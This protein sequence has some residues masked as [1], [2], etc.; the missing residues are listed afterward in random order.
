MSSDTDFYHAASKRLGDISICIDLS[1]LDMSRTEQTE[2]LS[3]NVKKDQNKRC[4]LVE[5]VKIN[6]HVDFHDDIPSRLEVMTL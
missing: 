5:D 1:N 2:Q 3:E 6:L 4:H